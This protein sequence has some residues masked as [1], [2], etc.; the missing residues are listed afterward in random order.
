MADPRA[1]YLNFVDP[2]YTAYSKT[3]T[4]ESGSVKYES[5]SYTY[6]NG[7]ITLSDNKPRGSTLSS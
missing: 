4:Y 2:D 6:N 3:V 7:E 5:G 1:P